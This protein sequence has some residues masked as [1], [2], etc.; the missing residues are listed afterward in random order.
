MEELCSALE[1]NQAGYLKWEEVKRGEGAYNYDIPPAKE[2]VERIAKL[3]DFPISWFY[4][5]E[6]HLS[7]PEY[8]S[9]VSGSQVL[10]YEVD[11]IIERTKAKK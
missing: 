2:V 8:F 5:D 4:A 1:I 11:E 10:D 6:I 9:P 3:L 7:K